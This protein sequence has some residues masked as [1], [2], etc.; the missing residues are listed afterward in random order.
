V[1]AVATSFAPPGVEPAEGAGRAPARWRRRRFLVGV[2]LGAVTVVAVALF[3]LGWVGAERTIHPE[4]DDPPPTLAGYPL[5]V[6]SV[7]FPSRDGT[8]LAGWWVAG[9]RDAG[10]V[11]LLHGYGDS[12]AYMLPHAFYLHAAGLNVLMFDFR[13][14]GESDGDA[15]TIGA[16]EQEDALGA[17]D[18]LAR[19]GDVDIRR[20]GLQGLSMGGAVAI[21][22]GARDQRV[23]GVIAEGPFKDVPSIID[24]EY[25]HQLGLPAFP[26][27]PITVAILERRLGVQAE[28]ISP[29]KALPALAGRPLLL[30]EG[31]QDEQVTPDNQRALYAA[32]SEPRELWSVPSAHADGHRVARQEYERRVLEFWAKAFAR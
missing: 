13:A 26:F 11:V 1:T 5:P 10:T 32:A 19:R 25:Q 27:A 30:I 28:D 7:E 22:A 29:I 18:Y 4:P 15:V 17:L 12:R 16:L 23:A 8:R 14:S 24:T 6:E 3:A 9:E 31:S 20:V 21:M 2:P